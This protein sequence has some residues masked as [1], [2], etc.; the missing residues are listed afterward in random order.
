LKRVLVV[1]V[2]ALLAAVPA[3]VAL[4]GSTTD[5]A[6][7][8]GQI[9]V[10]TG[11]GDTVAFTA[12]GTTDAAKGEVQIVDRTGGIGQGQTVFHGDV[13]CMEAENGMAEIGYRPKGDPAG[14]V[15]QLYVV[16][17]GEPNQGNDI[18]VIEENFDSLC[19][20]QNDSD[21][22]GTVALAR[23]NAQVYDGD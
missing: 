15:D 14:D 21:D 18:V 9:L 13:I 8:G 1:G 6:T 7:G 3:T 20:L 19:D 5:R 12:Q 2:G 16:D 23:G 17:N 11:A 4:G 22:D 10:S